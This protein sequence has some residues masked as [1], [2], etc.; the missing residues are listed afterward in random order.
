MKPV[1][2]EEL[3]KSATGHPTVIQAINELLTESGQTNDITLLQ[4]DILARIVKLDK[5]LTSKHVFDKHLL[6]IEDVYRA[7]G[8]KVEYD[9]PG[10]NETHYEPTFT[11]RAK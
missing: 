11:F 8:W 7:Q 1:S 10:W 2:P 5:K 3:R 4:K 9:K 6:D